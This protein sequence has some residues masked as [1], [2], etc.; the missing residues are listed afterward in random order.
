M[1]GGDRGS[2]GGR[3]KMAERAKDDMYK[4]IRESSEEKYQGETKNT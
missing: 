1:E 3:K 4:K 2:E